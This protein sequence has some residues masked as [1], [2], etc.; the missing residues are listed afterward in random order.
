MPRSKDDKEVQQ[1]YRWIL[2]GS[3]DMDL[4]DA[5]KET[6]PDKKPRSL[7]L[8]ALKRFEKTLEGKSSV[9]TGWCIEATRDLYRKSVKVGDF[10]NA[11]KAVKQLND[12]S[13]HLDPTGEEFEL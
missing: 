6:W 8:K 4:D 13:E 1:V 10:S 3:T 9:L 7:I 2:E 11:L 5:I 12:L